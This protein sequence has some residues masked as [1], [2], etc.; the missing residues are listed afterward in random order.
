MMKS[1]A[2]QLFEQF[3]DANNKHHSSA[4]LDIYR[5]TGGF[6]SQGT[7]NVESLSM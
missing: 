4:L 1:I 3:L 7:S 5:R 2:M 6:P